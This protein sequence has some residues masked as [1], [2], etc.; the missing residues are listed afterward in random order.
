MTPKRPDVV[1]RPA[2]AED[3]QG[4]AD[5]IPELLLDDPIPNK[6]VWA[7]ELAPHTVV[8]ENDGA[9]TG[10]V[11]FYT[12]EP[13]HVAT[14]VVHPDFRRLGYGR[15]LMQHASESLREPTKL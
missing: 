1:V 11:T 3:Y 10:F 5:L 2:I 12:G 6:H 7:E 9:I 15:A 8:L 14:L 4:V 13:A